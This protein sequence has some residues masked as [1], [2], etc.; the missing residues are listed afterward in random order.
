[1][2]VWVGSLGWQSGWIV[3]VVGGFR[4]DLG[5]ARWPLSDGLC[6]R[7]RMPRSAAPRLRRL[8]QAEAACSGAQ[9]PRS[10]QRVE[11]VRLGSDEFYESGG[12]DVRGTGRQWCSGDEV[13]MADSV[14]VDG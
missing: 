11:H 13:A 1:M 5:S 7:G 3:A 2:A 6:E 10:V 14:E 8:E 4:R 9:T 12:S